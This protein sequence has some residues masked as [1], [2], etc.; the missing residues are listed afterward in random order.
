MHFFYEDKRDLIY[1]NCINRVEFGAHIH[2]HL[3]IVYV[4]KGKTLAAADFNE[5]EICEGDVF[6]TF[7]NQVHQYYEDSI[8]EGIILIVSPKLCP[9]FGE[10]FKNKEPDMPIIKN[11]ESQTE[12]IRLFRT[13][14]NTF[15]EKPPFYDTYLKGCFLELLSLLFSRLEFRNQ[16]PV[17]KSAIKKILNYCADNYS[18]NISLEGAAEELYMNKCYISH[19]MKQKLNMGFRE[20][21]NM[22][23]ISESQRLLKSGDMTITDIAFTVGFNSTRSFNRAF[24]RELNMTPKEFKAAISSQN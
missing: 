7:P 2:E 11:A 18:V 23:R 24:Q 9:E 20:Y 19:L 16:L 1:T 22:L 17:D 6:L 15:E 10:L 13:I 12:I 4:I 5:V 3:E 8:E 14:V 21:I